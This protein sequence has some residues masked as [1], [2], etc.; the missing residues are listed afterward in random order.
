LKPPQ[1]DITDRGGRRKPTGAEHLTIAT[2]YWGIKQMKNVSK[3]I[4][5]VAVM[6]ASA[7]AAQAAA[8]LPSTD[9]SQLLFFV[10]D[11]TTHSTYTAILTQTVN[12][13]GGYFT[14]ADANA[15]GATTGVINT[16]TGDASFSYNFA[17]DSAL[18]SFISG[19]QTA[20]NTLDWGILAGAYSGNTQLN[21]EPTGNT[22]FVTMG[23]GSPINHVPES[24]LTN[25]SPV[26]LNTDV[27]KLNA[28]APFDSF[29][30]TTNGIFGTSLSA[31]GTNLST[32]GIGYTE[33][34]TAI[35]TT[36]YN[37]FGFSSTGSAGGQGLIFQL[38]TASFD[39]TTLAFTGN[40]GSTAV[41]LPAAAWLFGS[42]L[43]GLLGIG[44]RRETDGA[45][46]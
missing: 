11:L 42:G 20:G 40:A 5:G 4:M 21:R 29:N 31:N 2:N 34:G 30:G 46:A 45:A 25:T 38:G 19:A 18:Q 17:A 32:E 6:A 3:L 9:N 10:N 44:R 24:T 22:L 41:P 39:G 37:L 27:G 7:G 14:S 16:T 23:T 12:G 33:S 8:T 26:T 35:G 13:A 1:I 36:A 28:Q 43:L 15:A